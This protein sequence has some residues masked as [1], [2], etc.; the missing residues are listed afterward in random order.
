M[1]SLC[2]EREIAAQGIDGAVWLQRALH[3]LKTINAKQRADKR[4]LPTQ[5]A[6]NGGLRHVLHPSYCDVRIKIVQLSAPARGQQSVVNLL[7]ELKEQRI[8]ATNAHRQNLG[9]PAGRETPDPLQRQE[10]RFHAKLGECGFDPRRQITLHVAQKT[11]RQMQ[12]CRTR[13]CDAF[14]GFVQ[15][16]HDRPTWFG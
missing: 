10:E 2:A 3:E 1:T 5:P 8:T 12:L 7:A 13:P 16:R 9:R 11:H 4:V 6:I 15:F 14:D